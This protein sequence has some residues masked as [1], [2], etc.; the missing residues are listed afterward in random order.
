MQHRDSSSDH[1]H[2]LDAVKR[3]GQAHLELNYGD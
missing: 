2:I 3:K 1:D